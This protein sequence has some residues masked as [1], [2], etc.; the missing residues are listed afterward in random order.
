MELL[1]AVHITAGIVALVGAALALCSAKGNKLHRLSG[2]ASF[3]AMSAIFTTAIPMAIITGNI[4]LFLIAIFSFYLAFAG[5]QFAKNRKGIAK[6]ID[7]VAIGLVLI[8]GIGMWVLAVIY[9]LSQN[10]QYITLVVFG[11]IALAIGYQDYIRYKNTIA[12]GKKR[13]AGHLTHMMG[14]TI[15]VV[16]AVLVVNVSIEPVWIWWILPTLVI[17]P[18]ILW[19]N[20]KTLN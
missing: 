16:T 11:F 3:W 4:F 1:L 7:W 9:F 13:I 17:A 18:V 2:V 14:G 12:V 10:S 15:A 5:R 19:W 6:T 20:I 8:S